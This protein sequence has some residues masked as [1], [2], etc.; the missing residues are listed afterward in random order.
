[1][2]SL[3]MLAPGCTRTPIIKQQRAENSKKKLLA[4]NLYVE[5]DLLFCDH[6][7]S[8]IASDSLNKA[9]KKVA[10]GKVELHALRHTYAA[11]GAEKG[12]ALKVMQELLGHSDISVTSNNYTHISSD[13]RK[14]G[15]AKMSVI[16][17]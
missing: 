15:A 7:G 11:R 2:L 10:N 1:M 5:N 16:L 3:F 17:G 6:V 9:F 14:Q 8:L 12:V 13:L 4:G